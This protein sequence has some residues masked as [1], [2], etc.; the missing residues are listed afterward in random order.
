M[1]DFVTG[2]TSRD[3]VLPRLDELVTFAFDVMDSY[4]SYQC[5]M[6]A[7]LL[8]LYNEKLLPYKEKLIELVQQP[9][10]EDQDDR[11]TVPFIYRI[12][13]VLY[14]FPSNNLIDEYHMVAKSLEQMASVR[15]DENEM[16]DLYTTHLCKAM[17]AVQVFSFPKPSVRK[18]LLEYIESHYEYTTI[19]KEMLEVIGNGLQLFGDQI[20]K[21]SETM[22]IRAAC[23]MSFYVEKRKLM[24]Q[25]A[26]Y[27]RLTDVVFYL[28]TIQ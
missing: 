2:L 6:L 1:C 8:M 13:C 28:A 20:P 18:A 10:D 26:K 3:I 14:T 4:W 19:T 5:E 15:E 17:R 16:I 25:N 7:R 9:I 12:K 21:D 11:F 24:L 27:Q 22:I 23:I